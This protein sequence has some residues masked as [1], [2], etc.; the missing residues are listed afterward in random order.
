MAELHGMLKT[1]EESIK[2]SSSHVMMVQKDSK[3]RKR[4]G[5]AK[6]SDEISS[7]KPKP[8]GKPKASPAASD[9][10]HHCHKTGHWRRNCKLY[11]EELKKKKGSKT[12]SSGTEKD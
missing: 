9:T 5:K 4:K 1:A 6:T 7:S 3:K 12:S 11:L 2:K 8:V 10:C